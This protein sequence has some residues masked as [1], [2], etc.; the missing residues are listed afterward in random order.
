MDT[1][2]EVR[3]LVQEDKSDL[4]A[5]LLGLDEDGLRCRFMGRCSPESRS[6][7]AAGLDM[8]AVLVFGGFMDN[9]LV[10]VAEVHPFGDEGRAE[11]ALSVDASKRGHGIGA[12]L[13]AKALQEAARNGLLLIEARCLPLNRAMLAL[14][15]R[16][17][18]VTNMMGGCE[19]ISEIPLT[20]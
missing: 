11:L 15:R 1:D 10:G 9:H 20:A 7:Y 17:K 13:L 12:F 19:A 8:N 18:A 14:M 5:H 16:H 3:R 4:A 6:A 2:M